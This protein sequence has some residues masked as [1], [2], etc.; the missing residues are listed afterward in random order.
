MQEQYMLKISL[1]FKKNTGFKSY[2]LECEILRAS[3]LYELEYIDRFSNLHYCTFKQSLTYDFRNIS[4]LV[5]FLHLFLS[6]P[7]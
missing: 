5:N 6:T 3:F 2:G 4:K 7:V 1:P